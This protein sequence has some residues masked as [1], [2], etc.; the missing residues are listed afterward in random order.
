MKE[1]KNIDMEILKRKSI[2]DYKEFEASDSNL[3]RDTKLVKSSLRV[4]K[5]KRKKKENMHRRG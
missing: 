1:K 3:K 4:M 5:K 2:S